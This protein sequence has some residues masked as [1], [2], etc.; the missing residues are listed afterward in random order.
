MSDSERPYLDALRLLARRELSEAQVRERLARRG[1][2][3]GD[4]EAVVARLKA[5]Q[6]ID[7]GRAAA[8]IARK[9]AGRRSRLHARRTVEAA[10][11][12][13][14]TARRA[15]DEAFQSIDA[16]AALDAAL[17]RRLRGRAVADQAERQR[18]YRH[19]VARGFAPHKVLARL[20]GTP[21]QDDEP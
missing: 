7:D 2:A 12:A 21:A 16:D 9:A 10:G 3:P 17:A 4:I 5:A 18:L 13:P 8:A 15:V 19:L 11:I 20:G 14:E 1:H 6:A